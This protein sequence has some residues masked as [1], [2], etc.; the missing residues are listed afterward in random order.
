MILG[1]ISYLDC[2]VFLVSLTPQLLIHVNL[3]DLIVCVLCALPFFCMVAHLLLRNLLS[4]IS[5]AS[6]FQLAL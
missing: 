4:D 5:Q 3:I 1:Q 6:C 2:L